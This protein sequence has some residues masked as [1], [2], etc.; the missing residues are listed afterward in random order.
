MVA[1][2]AGGG[3][4]LGIVSV[5]WV[6]GRRPSDGR[7]LDRVDGAA[8][9]RGGRRRRSFCRCWRG[10]ALVFGCRGFQVLR[11]GARSQWGSDDGRTRRFG[12]DWRLR[13]EREAPLLG[14]ASADELDRAGEQGQGRGPLGSGSGG[15]CPRHGR[16]VVEPLGRRLAARWRL[17]VCVGGRRRC[18]NRRCAVGVA[19]VAGVASGSPAGRLGRGGHR[20][21]RCVGCCSRS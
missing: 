10:G 16:A 9:G 17:R 4:D 1:S 18:G 8:R 6:L 14:H 2:P 3:R 7:C 21:R 15:V 5:G 12:V 19:V 20:G 13:A 11:S